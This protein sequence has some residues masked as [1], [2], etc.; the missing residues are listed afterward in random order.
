[1]VDYNVTI[2]RWQGF[3][4]YNTTYAA[5][6]HDDDATLDF[7]GGDTG[8]PETITINGTLYNVSGTGT[9]LMNYIDNDNGGV[10][11][12]GEEMMFMQVPGSPGNGSYMMLPMAGSSFTAGDKITGFTLGGS[13]GQWHNTSGIPYS[14]VVCFTSGCSVLTPSGTRIIDDLRVGDTVTTADNGPQKICW[15]GRSKMSNLEMPFNSEIQPIRIRKDAFGEGMPD[16][17]MWVSPQHRILI[18]GAWVEM[19]FGETEVFV[20]A[21]GLLSDRSVT[22]DSRVNG[23]EYIHILFERHE[24]LFVNGIR[25]ESFHPGQTG[26]NAVETSARQELFTIFPQ[27]EDNVPGYGQTARMSLKV[28]ETQMLQQRMQF[29]K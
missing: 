14:S 16:R 2:F 15:I 19:A 27:L 10:A 25:T 26:L 7:F 12:I 3:S 23:V 9:I 6:I 29:S 17:D 22:V 28:G 11:V 5:T 1:M 24:V 20:P 18:S 8:T 4:T 21:K 13:S